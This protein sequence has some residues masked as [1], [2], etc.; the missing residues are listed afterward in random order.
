MIE[1]EKKYNL[2]TL[3][4]IISILIIGVTPVFFQIYISMQS[5]ALGFPWSMRRNVGIRNYIRILTSPD[6]YNSLQLTV[7]FTIVVT[8]VSLVVGLAMALV[9]NRDFK[10]KVIV[11]TS[12]LIP[13]T[14][15]PSILGLTWKLMYNAEYGI[16]NY[17]LRPFGLDQIWLGKNLAFVSVIITSIWLASSFMT[18]ISLAGLQN[19][20][21]DVFESAK[22]DGANALQIFYHI[23]LPLLKPI[24]GIA[25]LLQQVACLHIFGIIYTLTG[26]GPGERTN[27]LALEIYREGLDAG[28]VGTGAGI[29]T[30]LA[31]LAL[32]LSFVFIKLMGKEFL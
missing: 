2:L 15:S 6:F 8:L 14:I 12:I 17:F 29:A 26:G 21:E 27:V 32:I 18:L 7:I 5:F 1:A 20:P 9:I 28:F 11:V 25:I 19:L 10:F 3:P 16:I 23:T 31:I 4:A 22:I 24:L 13:Q 30:F